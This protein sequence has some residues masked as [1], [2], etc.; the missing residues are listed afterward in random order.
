[1]ILMMTVR[2]FWKN[3]VAKMCRTRISPL[4]GRNGQKRRRTT[5]KSVEGESGRKRENIS[6]IYIS[7]GDVQRLKGSCKDCKMI[8][9]A[10]TEET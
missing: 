9:Q 8:F 2:I 4:D 6:R 3:P 10:R 7:S 5:K 1:M